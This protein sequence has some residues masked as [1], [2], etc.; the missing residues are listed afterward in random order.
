[1]IYEYNPSEDELA[2][3]ECLIYGVNVDYDYE[4]D[5][6]QVIAELSKGIKVGCA[7][8][9]EVISKY[10]SPTKEGGDYDNLFYSKKANDNI[11]NLKNNRAVFAFEDGILVM[12]SM[13]CI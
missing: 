7:K 12:V 13:K 11:L 10:G 2:I 5:E 3:R 1:M 8:R 4:Y 9:D 6:P